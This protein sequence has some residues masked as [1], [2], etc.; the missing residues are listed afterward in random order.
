MIREEPKGRQLLR[1]RKQRVSP[2]PR[3]LSRE[4]L[5]VKPAVGPVSVKIAPR[6][7]PNNGVG[8]VT[9]RS[10]QL[11]T[12]ALLRTGAI[13]YKREYDDAKV[14][15]VCTLLYTLLL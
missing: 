15:G 1:C 9:Q 3:Q 13:L 10:P 12:E 7:L 11:S 5:G 4:W 8:L 6:Q 14:L 2:S